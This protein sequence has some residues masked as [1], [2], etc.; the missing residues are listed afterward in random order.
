MGLAPYGNQNSQRT[1][2][3]ISTIKSKLV[4][5]KADGSFQLNLK[6]FAFT[7]SNSTCNYKKWAEIFGLKQRKELTPI[8][9]SYC[10]L[11]FA[12]QRV[13]EEIVLGL[14]KQ[15]KKNNRF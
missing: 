2:D 15:A 4:S 5:I 9:N 12:I 8:T 7:Y 3:F 13:T 11:A 10:D 6:Y 1:Q 14:V